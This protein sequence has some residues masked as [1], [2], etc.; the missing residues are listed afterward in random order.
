MKTQRTPPAFTLIELLVVISIIALLAA[1]LTPMLAS[2]RRKG[3]ATK[4]LANLK[5]LGTAAQ[6]CWDD[7]GDR[8]PGLSGLFP[9]WSNTTVTAWTKAL[10]PYTR[11]TKVFIE[12]DLPVWMPE[13]P[14]SYYLNLLPAC[15]PPNTAS[16]VTAGTYYVMSRRIV[17]TSA[18]VLLSEDLY[19][20]PQQEIDPSNE[21][22]DRTGFSPGSTCFPPPHDGQANFLFADGHV[23][24]YKSFV[25]GSMTF[26][27]D[28]LANWQPDV[29]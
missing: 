29:P 25:N 6:M 15:V 2:A 11:S 27:Y 10:Y 7:N 18:F 16:T 3:H 9:T 20:A 22:A 24:A 5:Q 14:V 4:C 26:W 23:G 19:V 1:L 12:R 8:I 28:A 17:N 13:L 21:T